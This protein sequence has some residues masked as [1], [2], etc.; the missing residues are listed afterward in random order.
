MLIC[1]IDGQLSTYSTFHVSYLCKGKL[2]LICMALPMYVEYLLQNEPEY[3]SYDRCAVANLIRALRH[4]QLR[5][6]ICFS[7]HISRISVRW[8]HT[9]DATD[10]AEVLRTHSAV[11]LCFLMPMTLCS[12]RAFDG[13]SFTPAPLLTTEVG[14]VQVTAQTVN[15]MPCINR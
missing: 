6:L 9:E 14:S 15:A 1:A 5:R 8:K 12:L 10:A 13:C 4:W 2:V 7:E 3:V 11:W